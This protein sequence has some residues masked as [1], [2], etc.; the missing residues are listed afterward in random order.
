MLYII[1]VKNGCAQ[2]WE[3][4]VESAAEEEGWSRESGKSALD[5]LQVNCG[6]LIIEVHD[7]KA[8]EEIA[9]TYQGESKYD[10]REK[11][12]QI[13]RENGVADEAKRRQIESLCESKNI[14]GSLENGH[15]NI[16]YFDGKYAHKS[17]L[18]KD[19]FGEWSAALFDE[20]EALKMLDIADDDDMISYLI[21]HI[22]V[23]ENGKNN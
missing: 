15:L 4:S 10:I 18:E 2:L 19:E 23:D 13:L 12:W 16:T 1:A 17:T 14:T 21:D 22:G 20:N 5:F 11:A 6:F 8:A 9:T 7:L 3:T